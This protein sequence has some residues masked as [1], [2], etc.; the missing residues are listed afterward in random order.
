M[1]ELLI[2]LG[3][4]LRR[5][6]S[7]SK[8][9]FGVILQQKSSKFN[10]RKICGD[11]KRISRYFDRYEI[12]YRRSIVNRIEIRLDFALPCIL[13]NRYIKDKFKSIYY[14]LQAY[15][16]FLLKYY[17]YTLI[18]I[19]SFIVWEELQ[20]RLNCKSMEIK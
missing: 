1:L 7:A 4:F 14:K 13:L 11:A 19:V 17:L 6:K 9:M 10:K 2:K 3:V 18:D 5:D 8:A 16:D 12:S 15:K 20:E